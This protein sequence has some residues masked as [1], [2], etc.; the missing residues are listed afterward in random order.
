MKL[1]CKEKGTATAPECDST[2]EEEKQR[3]VEE[4]KK[5]RE[6]K[7]EKEKLE[8][9]RALQEKRNR[10]KK[11]STNS[12]ASLRVAGGF[13]ALKKDRTLTER[14]WRALKR[15]LPTTQLQIALIYLSPFLALALIAFVYSR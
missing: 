10:K 11:G 14:A 7:R 1:Q 15:R 5:Q 6:A 8:L 12:S 13:V 4:L 9:D 2:C 3:R